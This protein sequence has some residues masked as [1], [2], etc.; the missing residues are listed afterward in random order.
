MPP[1]EFF[2][3]IHLTIKDCVTWRE[4]NLEIIIKNYKTT[5]SFLFLQN[6]GINKVVYKKNCGL[7]LTIAFI[8]RE[9]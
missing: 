6:Y 3:M 5:Y 8:L 7:D 4:K 2:Q 9:I 1:D